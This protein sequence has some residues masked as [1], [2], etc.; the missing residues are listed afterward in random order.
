MIDTPTIFAGLIFGSIGLGYFIYGK[1]QSNTAVKWTGVALIVYPYFFNNVLMLGAVG[2]V[3]MVLP[4]FI[5]L[6]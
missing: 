2:I 5:D 4:R 6:D 3:L 1:K